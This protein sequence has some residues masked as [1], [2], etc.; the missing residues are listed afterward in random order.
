MRRTKRKDFK[1]GAELETNGTDLFNMWLQ[2]SEDMSRVELKI[3]R[4]S[5]KSTEG[6]NKWHTVKK[7]DLIARYGEAK[8]TSIMNRKLKVSPAR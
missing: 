7:R 2:E 6:Q 5:E 4:S 1:L 3:Q 8:A